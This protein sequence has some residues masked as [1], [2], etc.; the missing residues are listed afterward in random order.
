MN[1]QCCGSD[2]EG[3]C[4]SHSGAGALVAALILAL[5]IVA[6]GYFVGSGFGKINAV[7]KVEVRGLAEREVQADVALWPLKLVATGDDLAVLQTKLEADTKAIVGFLIGQG[8]KEEE[9]TRGRM[10]VTDLMASSYRSESM[11]RNRFIVYANVTVKSHRVELVQTASNSIGSVIR[12]GIVLSQETGGSLA[13][14]F[15]FTKLNDIKP[16]MLAESTRNARAAAEQFAR[17][18]GEP[19]GRMLRA[20]QGTFSIL[21]VYDTGDMESRQLMKK[22]RVVSTVVFALAN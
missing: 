14:F 18:S 1:K 22:I 20:E 10:E 21:P 7:N 13:P 9:I 19:L 5:G 8:L 6:G 12:S 3:C 17:D 2:N 16:D 15:I 4:S 11:T